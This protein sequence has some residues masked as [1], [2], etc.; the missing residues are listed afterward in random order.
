MLCCL[1]LL[2]LG[3]TAFAGNTPWPKWDN[4]IGW[5]YRAHYY[6]NAPNAQGPN[7]QGDSHM[8][9]YQAIDFP[10]SGF[11]TMI[12]GLNIQVHDFSGGVNNQR[13]KAME[14]RFEGAQFGNPDWSANGL[15]SEVLP[16]PYISNWASLNQYPFTAPGPVGYPV[17]SNT[18]AVVQYTP[19]QN[20]ITPGCPLVACD[21]GV[22]GVA[23]QGTG[24]GF[25][26]DGAL[27]SHFGPVIHTCQAEYFGNPP[28]PPLVPVIRIANRKYDTASDDNSMCQGT[29]LKMT[30]G[31]VNSTGMTWGPGKITMY[32]HEGQRNWIWYSPPGVDLISALSGGSKTNPVGIRVP[33]GGIA[34]GVKLDNLFGQQGDY[35]FSAYTLNTEVTDDAD[36]SYSQTDTDDWLMTPKGAQDGGYADLYWWFGTGAVWGRGFNKFFDQDHFPSG[37]FTVT[38]VDHA[39]EDWNG[40]GFP[41]YRADVRTEATLGRGQSD[42]SNAG[43][44]GTFDARIVT[45]CSLN[46]ALAYD[47]TGAA[48]IGFASVPTG[49]IYVDTFTH[50]GSNGYQMCGST[51]GGKDYLPLGDNFYNW[52]GGTRRYGAGIGAD[53]AGQNYVMRLI[54]TE[55][56]EGSGWDTT[57][58]VVA[59]KTP[60]FAKMRK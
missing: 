5:N 23:L 31:L 3:G 33:A 35:L 19:G 36:P 40:N 50:P 46:T 20:I 21:N 41:L 26:Y 17:G 24:R 57:A 51:N 9:Q 60:V 8:A 39:R 47:T 54:M 12:V 16:V 2:F 25:F 30:V 7:G 37:A 10:N 15:I 4:S 59:S 56:L 14:M 53:D 27:M 34:V 1:A 43:L 11:G 29:G 58:R 22:G 45:C 52:G 42:L 28:P 6:M 13:F 48:G 38:R 44:L 32:M 18:L 49:N 55:P